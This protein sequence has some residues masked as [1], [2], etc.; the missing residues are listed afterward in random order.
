VF[1]AARRRHDYDPPA[2][3]VRAPT[4]SSVRV[5]AAAVAVLA[6]TAVPPALAQRSAAAASAETTS[7]ASAAGL[8]R[9]GVRAL[10]EKLVALGYLAPGGVDGLYGGETMAAVIAFQKWELLPRDGIAGPVTR[11]VLRT[12]E[13]PKPVTR[14]RG[15]RVE[16]LLD[17]QL[18]LLIRRNKVWRA[19]HVSTGKRRFETPTGSYAILRKRRRSWSI[20]YKV[21]LPWASYFVGGYAVHQSRNVPTYAA[22]HGCVRVTRYEGRWLFNRMLVGTPVRVIART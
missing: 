19:S 17:R 8:G 14:A 21:W 2:V 3:E 9:K 7:L 22:S 15:V 12:A 18:L 20:P 11:R 1:V 16:I 6:L 13:R 4:P 10:Q 5:A